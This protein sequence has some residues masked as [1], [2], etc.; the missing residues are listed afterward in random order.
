MK[1]RG[2]GHI[3]SL[4]DSVITL[5]GLATMAIMYHVVVLDQNYVFETMT[6]GSQ[7]M[8]YNEAILFLEAS[9]IK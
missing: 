7:E 5:R 6:L 3:R 1:R 9:V 2:S 8:N 4:C